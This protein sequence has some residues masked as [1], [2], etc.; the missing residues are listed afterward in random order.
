[1][2][3]E[4]VIFETDAQVVVKALEQ[5]VEDNSEFG[6][7]MSTCH[8]LLES[9]PLYKVQFVKRNPN[10]VAHVLA[11]Q[12]RFAYSLYGYRTSYLVERGLKLCL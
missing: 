6:V 4:Q 11:R 3:H 7:I 9:K 12:P 2:G 1:M 8:L 10:D 5:D